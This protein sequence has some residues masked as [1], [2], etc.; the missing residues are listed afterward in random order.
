MHASRN[1]KSVPTAHD[2]DT[3]AQ[4]RQMVKK[5]A[6]VRQ[7]QTFHCLG[8]PCGIVCFCYDRLNRGAAGAGLRRMR[9]GGE[10]GASC[11][12]VRAAIQRVYL[13]A[14]KFTSASAHQA[15]RLR[16]RWPRHGCARRACLTSWPGRTPLR[17]ARVGGEASA[18]P[19][20][21]LSASKLRGLRD[22]GESPGV[23]CRLASRG[24]PTQISAP[25]C[26]EVAKAAVSGTCCW[27]AHVDGRA[28]SRARR[29][30]CG[31]RRGRVSC[32][33]VQRG[34]ED[35]W[36]ISEDHPV[37]HGPALPERG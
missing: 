15:A 32:L 35:F 28:G 7:V 10:L 21:T 22:E 11:C 27:L 6:D 4:H 26:Q 3:C 34:I 36:T 1:V 5:Y 30:R 9:F 13:C 12:I 33:L 14:C 29:G 20:F 19:R 23:C 16:K 17:S 31:E 25:A 37:G 8:R 24:G 2:R 18:P